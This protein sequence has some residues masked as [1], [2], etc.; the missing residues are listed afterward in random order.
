MVMSLPGWNSGGGLIASNVTAAAVG[1]NHILY[2]TKD[3]QL[4]SMG[5]NTCG[6]L[7][8][9]TYTDQL[10]APVHVA[11]A[12]PVA[13]I[14]AGGKHSL[15]VTSDGQLMAMGNDGSGQLGL[16]SATGIIPYPVQIQIPDAVLTKP[17]ENTTSGVTT[18]TGS[19]A[20]SNT[21]ASAAGNTGGSAGGGAPSLLYLAS[22]FALLALRRFKRR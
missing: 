5:W 15:Y 19:N 6:Q 1:D 11:E 18:T 4:W 8:N 7:G 21:S 14:A 16:G 2:T 17:V 3:G 20:A 22:A 10:T 9:G 13:A 12:S